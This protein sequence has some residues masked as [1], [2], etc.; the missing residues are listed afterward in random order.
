M[1]R[2]AGLCLLSFGLAF[3]Q[4]PSRNIPLVVPAGAPLR[5]YLTKRV[6]RRLNAPVQAKML[7]PLYAFDR[8]VVPAGSEVFGT[9]T[10][11]RNAASA[12]RAKALM[13]GD[14]TPLHLAEV[15]FTSI[16][17]ANGRQIAID[18]V[19]SVELN[20][21]VPVKPPKP[22]SQK[23]QNDG[24][25][26]AVKDQLNARVSAVKSIPDVVRAPGKKDLLEDFL[27]A[28]LPYHPQFVRSRTRFDAELSQSLDFGSATVSQ[29][30]LA[31][32]GS[33][34]TADSTVHARLVTPVGSKES[35]PGQTVRAVL[36]QP[37]FSSDHRLIFPEGTELDGTVVLAKKAGWLHHA[38]RVRFTFEN[39]QLTPETLS[40]LASPA[41]LPASPAEERTL[42]FR[43]QAT[44]KAAE[45]SGSQIKVDGEGG[46]QATESKTRFIGVALA[47]AVAAHSGL[48]D[49]KT[50]SSGVTTQGRNTGGRLLGGGSGMG[51]LGGIAGQ[52]SANTSLALGYYGLA[53]TVYFG[54]I[55]RG[56]E[57]E[58]LKNA[59][60]DIGFD[61]R[62]P[63]DNSK[64]RDGE[65][66]HD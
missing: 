7:A 61:V 54:V 62:K 11:L 39:I 45:S 51:L 50:N 26:G 40:L 42:Q 13:S 65:T 23:Q 34:P 53:R 6:P 49:P 10:R 66:V 60:V 64:V 1:K 56:P 52:L 37:L 43:T 41:E 28:K 2:F 31:Q 19:E 4:D 25:M 44:L 15:R 18:T 57:A 63:I 29:E 38:G 3:G 30:S 58:F 9:V 20:S 14:F 12:E 21:V 36:D 47:A 35:A 48:G 27:W 55:A 24:T 17:L 8:E 5:L 59:V 33:Q 46:V 32:L 16:H 22:A